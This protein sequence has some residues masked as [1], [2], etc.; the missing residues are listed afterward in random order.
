MSSGF[1]LRPLLQMEEDP[2]PRQGL[3]SI[4]ALLWP[5]P[6]QVLTQGQ[7]LE[8]LMEKAQAKESTTQVLEQEPKMQVMEQEPKVQVMEQEPKVQVME[9]EPKVQVM[10]LGRVQGLEQEKVP[11]DDVQ[12]L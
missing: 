12:L 2:V 5:W 6:G 3:P 7:N 11:H 1:Q 8:L 4:V 10:E 9:Q